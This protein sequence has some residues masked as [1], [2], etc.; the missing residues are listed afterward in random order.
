MMALLQQLMSA[1]FKNFY[2]CQKFMITLEVA[3]NFTVSLSD[4]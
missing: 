4:V 3:P 2:Q 1:F